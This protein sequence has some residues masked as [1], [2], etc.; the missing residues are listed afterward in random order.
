[1]LLLLASSFSLFC[2][3]Q[4]VELHVPHDLPSHFPLFDAS[5]TGLRPSLGLQQQQQ[6]QQQQHQQPP[7]LAIV[8]DYVVTS[9]EWPLDCETVNRVLPEHRLVQSVALRSSNHDHDHNHDYKHEHQHDHNHNHNQGRHH[10]DRKGDEARDR[11]Q[12]NEDRHDQNVLEEGHSIAISLVVF[13]HGCELHSESKEKH[14]GK[15]HPELKAKHSGDYF[16]G[17]VSIW[18]DLRI[19]VR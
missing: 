18:K 15:L 14:S 10:N 12:L 7:L 19:L 2:G 9:L 16:S 11:D 5:L 6:Q 8:G 13:I 4:G 1:M 17:V 3:I